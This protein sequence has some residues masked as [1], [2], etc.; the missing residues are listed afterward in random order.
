MAAPQQFILRW[1]YHDTTIFQNLLRFF[2]GDILTDVTLSVGTKRVKAHKVI[3]GMCS[4][5][6]LQLFQV[7]FVLRRFPPVDQSSFLICFISFVTCKAFL[8]TKGYCYMNS[9]TN[10]NDF[11][12]SFINSSQ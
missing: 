8:G 6:F 2:D 11:L 7:V 1:H 10:Q 3:L 9:C 5:Y 4:V 12:I